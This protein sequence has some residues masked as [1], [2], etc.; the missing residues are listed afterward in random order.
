[1]TYVTTWSVE[2]ANVDNGV[3]LDSD[4][5]L[6]LQ[7][8]Q[9]T[10]SIRERNL[11]LTLCWT[12]L[13]FASWAPPPWIKTFPEP[14]AEIASSQTSRNQTL[15]KVQA[16]LQWTPSSWFLPMMTLEME[17]PFSKMKTAL[18]DPVS[19]SVLQARPRSNSLLPKSTEP[20]MLD[21]LESEMMLPERVGMLRVWADAKVA[22]TPATIAVVNC[23][24]KKR[25]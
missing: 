15:V 21:A 17:A 16:P 23:I 19:S 11:R 22:R 7:D 8:I 3:V 18:A 5:S 4:S 1:M 13:S 25:V 2:L 14:R 9:Q 24:L 10:R 20:L 6:S 12:T